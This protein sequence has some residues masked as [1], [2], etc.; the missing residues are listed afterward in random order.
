MKKLAVILVALSLGGCSSV[1]R[2]MVKY[3]ASNMSDESVCYQMGRALRDGN[4]EGAEIL[5]Q[6]VINRGVDRDMCVDYAQM[7]SRK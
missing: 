1:G 7:G 5:R 2:S 4:F 3:A 6:E